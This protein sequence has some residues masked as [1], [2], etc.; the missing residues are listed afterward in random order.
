MRQLAFL[1]VAFFS[2]TIST[3]IAG[4][5]PNVIVCLPVI[6]VREGEQATLK[7]TITAH[8]PRWTSP[9]GGLINSHDFASLSPA[10][11]FRSRMGI[12]TNG[13]LIIN[14]TRHY[15]HGDY[16]CF[17]PGYGQQTVRLVVSGR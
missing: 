10:V 9:S 16:Q 17:Y 6:N 13:D 1:L 2:C 11:P 8:I 3:N 7:C 14:N 5:G 15:D 4:Y 12:S